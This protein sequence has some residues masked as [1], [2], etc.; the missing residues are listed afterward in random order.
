[1]GLFANLVL[2]A[3]FAFLI[4]QNNEPD[5]WPVATQFIIF[6][7]WANALLP[8]VLNDKCIT[9]IAPAFHA[10]RTVTFASLAIKKLTA[11]SAWIHLRKLMILIPANLNHAEVGSYL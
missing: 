4:F 3:V 5:A 9:R 8:N 6:L 1:M 10:L 7:I 11:L 2:F